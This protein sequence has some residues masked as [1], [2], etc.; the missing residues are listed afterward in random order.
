LPDAPQTVA[1]R[2]DL[3]LG[4]AAHFHQH[5]GQMIYLQKELLTIDKVLEEI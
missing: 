5:L 2:F 3:F 4:G 1:N